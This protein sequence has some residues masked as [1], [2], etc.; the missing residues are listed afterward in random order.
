MDSF[1]IFF[2]SIHSQVGRKIIAALRFDTSSSS[3]LYPGAS[4][5]TVPCFSVRGTASSDGAGTRHL[6]QLKAATY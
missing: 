2:E 4:L 5:C 3:V 6:F 1:E